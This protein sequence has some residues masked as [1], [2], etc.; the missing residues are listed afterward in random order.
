MSKVPS[1]DSKAA[2][3]QILPSF[4]FMKDTHLSGRQ[5]EKLQT[6]LNDILEA[7]GEAGSAGSGISDTVRPF[8]ETMTTMLNDF[9]NFKDLKDP[10]KNALRNKFANALNVANAFF[11]QNAD[12]LK[13]RTGLLMELTDRNITKSGAVAN[14]QFIIS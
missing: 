4:A 10:A 12:T 1:L 9:S 11:T 8:T 3:Q 5:F 6:Q 2:F 13:S 7:A 14:N